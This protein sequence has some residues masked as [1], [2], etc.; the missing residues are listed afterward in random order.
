MVIVEQ[1]DT[2]EL[3]P[4]LA[5]EYSIDSCTTPQAAL[6]ACAAAAYKAVLIGATFSNLHRVDMLAELR[7]VA[8]AAAFLAIYP[9]SKADRNEEA[10][11]LGYVGHLL[12]P[13]EQAAINELR[14][15]WLGWKALLHR[16][17]TEFRPEAF[18][19]ES[20]YLNEYFD[21]LM[22]LIEQGLDELAAACESE[23]TLDLSRLPMHSIRT[24]EFVV[25]AQET[26]KARGIEMTVVGPRD[27]LVM[28]HGLVPPTP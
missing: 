16:T 12:R 28:G 5:A 22:T 8:P 9:R 4:L 15:K 13:Y 20:R 1:L 25:H 19:Y 10:R 11:A 18:P 3:R 26:A 27:V 7:A 17:A 2:D 6:D 24:P 14:F 21:V 23:I